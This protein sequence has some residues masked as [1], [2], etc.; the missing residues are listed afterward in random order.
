MEQRAGGETVA[1]A[2]EELFALL[3]LFGLKAVKFHSRPSRLVVE[4]KVGSPPM[5]RRTSWALSFLVDLAAEG[6]DLAPL[7]LAVGEGDARRFHHARDAMWKSNLVSISSA[8]LAPLIGAAVT[9]SEVAASGMWPSP[10]SRPEVGIEADPA[11]AGEID[12]GPGV[13][14]GEVGFGAGRAAVDRLHV[15]GQ[16]D[17]IARDEPGGEAELAATCTSSQA[18]SRQEPLLSP[19]VSSTVCTPGSSRT[20]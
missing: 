7:L 10:V 13:E 17:E 4:T 11:R 6:L 5:V 9:G 16:L 19:S 8:S 18:E 12:L 3:L 14:I 1:Q 20:T 2:L 15:G